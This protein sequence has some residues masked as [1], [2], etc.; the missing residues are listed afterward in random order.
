MTYIKFR[1]IIQ[2]LCELIMKVLLRILDFSHIKLP[3]PS[4]GILLVYLCW[5][6]PL[7]FRE[8]NIYEVLQEKIHLDDSYTFSL[9][10]RQPTIIFG[11]N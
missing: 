1:E 7:R 11:S 10:V 4:Y 8:Y 2:D 6:F 9:F 5:C 3:D